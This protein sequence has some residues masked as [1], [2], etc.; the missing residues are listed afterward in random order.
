MRKLPRLAPVVAVLIAALPV[1][2]QTVTSEEERRAKKEERATERQYHPREEIIVTATM[3]PTALKNCSMAASIVTQEDLKAL[4]VSNALNALNSQ[5]GIFV[6]RTGD[7]GRADIEIRGLGQR[8]QR[9][10]V[11]VDGRPEKMGIFGCV[12]TQTFPFDNVERLEVVRGPAAV[13]YGTD[14][15]GG[16][17][18]IITHTPRDGWETEAVGSYGSFDTRRFTLRHGAG[19]EKV[20]Y[21]LTYDDSRSDGHIPDSSYSGR[22]L[23]GK[24]VLDVGRDWH[25]A[26]NGKYYDGKKYEPLITYTADP[27]EEIWNDYERGGFDLTLS[28]KKHFHDLNLKTYMDFG[29]HVLSDGWHSRDYVYGGIFRYTSTRWKNNELTLGADFRYLSGRS[30]NFPVGE[31]DKSEAAVFVQNQYV[32][33]E[34]LILTGGLRANRDSVYGWEIIPSAGFVFFLKDAT[35]VRGVISK[36]FRSP[37]LNEL[38][39]FP[40]SNPDLLPER[41]WNYELGFNHQFLTRFD[42]D[43]TLFVM[44][45]SDLIELTANPAP[46]P[47]FKM[48][49]VGLYKARGIEARLTG[50]ISPGLTGSASMTLLDP[51]EHTL[52]KAGQ[53]YDF[54]LIFEKGRL[55]SAVTAQYVTDYY[56]GDDHTNRLNSFFLL[57]GKLDLNISRHFGVFL[58]LNNVFDTAYQ[59]YVN[60]PGQAAGAYPMPG[61]SVSAGLRIKQ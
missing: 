11:M 59:I 27:P 19:F 56:A 48:M 26:L 33:K 3:V 52:G 34:K 39:L 29:H 49:N 61:R 21:Y 1:L 57:N 12:I 15:L 6:M 43:L 13:L 7:F 20:S 51:G 36:G 28:R 37:Q 47:Q 42:L 25:V 55:F 18:N 38:Y 32:F 4:D 5:P 16:A 14:A 44:R 58:N 53:K 2:S 40:T 17:V 31:W 54:S 45:T 46:P 41:N 35:S 50:L 30:Y 9:I 22:S 24:A 8:G 10:G 60:L 23:T